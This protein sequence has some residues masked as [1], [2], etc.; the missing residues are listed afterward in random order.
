[1]LNIQSGGT[2][3]ETERDLGEIRLMHRVADNAAEEVRT[4]ETWRF[5]AVSARGSAGRLQRRSDRCGRGAPCAPEDSVDGG[6][7]VG[8]AISAK[9]LTAPY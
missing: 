6:A 2:G 4:A 3:T 5:G 9:V 7:A 8:S 1:M